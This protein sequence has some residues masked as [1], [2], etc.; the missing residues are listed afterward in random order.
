MTDRPTTEAAARPTP[1]ELVFGD[2]IEAGTFPGIRDEAAE[3]GVDPADPERFGFLSLAADAVRAVV[4]PDSPSEALDQYRALL[5]HA[6]SFWRAGKHTYRLDPAL[7]RYL[8]EGAPS[9]DEWELSLPRPAVYLQL[10]RNLFWGSISPDSTP[11]SVDG[12]FVTMSGPAGGAGSRRMEVLMVLGIRRDRPGFSIIP[13]SAGAGEGVAAAWLASPGRDEGRD[14]ENVLPG[15]EIQGLYS[16]LTSSEVL[17]LIA[18]AAW[19]IDN[20]PGD[21]ELGEP[22][23]PGPTSTGDAADDPDAPLASPGGGAPAAAGQD[24]RVRLGEHGGGG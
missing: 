17:K 21:V 12:F 8:V 3:R 19:Y 23:E 13:V 15:G 11:E 24:H 7:C 10:P 5:Y 14:F 16:I 22:A 4:Q 9:L 2:E 18:R 6:Y 1:Y 20:Y